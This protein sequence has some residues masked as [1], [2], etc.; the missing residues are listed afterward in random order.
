M[1]TKQSSQ[2]RGLGRKSLD[3]MLEKI[4][5]AIVHRV[6]IEIVYG[7]AARLLEP[8][9]LRFTKDGN[10]VL[11][12]RKVDTEKVRTYRL[13]RIE[14]VKVTD[15]HFVPVFAIEMSQGGPLLIQP[16]AGSA[17]YATGLLTPLSK[18]E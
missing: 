7:G 2:R 15:M 10:V 14:T 3:A 11:Y 1:D 4:R 8:Y 5:Y 6:C 16:P 12:S 17:K 13:D 9:S 18:E